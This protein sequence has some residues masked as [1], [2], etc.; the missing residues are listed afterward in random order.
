MR[1]DDP[2]YPALTISGYMLGGGFLNSRLATRI[3]QKE[4]LSYGVGGSFR[5]DPQDK[6]AAFSA[7]M[8]Y[9][10]DNLAKLEVAFR[11][12][13]ERAQREG[14]TAQELEAAKTG[15]LRS[16]KVTRSSDAGLAGS[17]NSYLFYKRDFNWN[18]QREEKVQ[19]LTLE[20]VNA[21][22]KKHL[23]FSKMI[24]VKAGSFKPSLQ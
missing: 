11:E 12:E 21:A 17:L 22:T 13:I 5:A 9:N 2:E 24:L 16:Q 6:D 20:E 18:A 4:G 7:R 14:F 8:I 23:D 19:G 3:R 1:D 15:W 10:P